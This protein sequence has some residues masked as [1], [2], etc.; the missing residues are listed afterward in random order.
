MRIGTAALV[1][2]CGGGSSV[3]A[4]ATC[5]LNHLLLFLNTTV[6]CRLL[7]VWLPV[8]AQRC[9]HRF[10]LSR[11]CSWPQL[12]LPS[13]LVRGASLLPQ[14]LR[15]RDLPLSVLD[16]QFLFMCLIRHSLVPLLRILWSPTPVRS[17]GHSR[18]EHGRLV[19]EGYLRAPL[20]LLL[21]PH[22]LI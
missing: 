6:H 14:C 1:T 7:H 11:S 19:P 2:C 22:K 9:P 21:P 12:Q 20:L 4:F 3:I 16:E 8:A 13:S 15:G 17:A 10:Q 18:S 5:T